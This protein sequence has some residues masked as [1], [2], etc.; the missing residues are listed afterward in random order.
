MPGA[1][2]PAQ[3]PA[4]LDQRLEILEPSDHWLH[5]PTPP[6]PVAVKLLPEATDHWWSLAF[7]V[8]KVHGDHIELHKARV[9]SESK[10]W[11]P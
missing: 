2:D 4:S 5:S 10:D 1:L 6:L 7:R 11:F 9:W 8:E 3:R